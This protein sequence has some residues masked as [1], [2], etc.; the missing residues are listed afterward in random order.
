MVLAAV[1]LGLLPMHSCTCRSSAPEL[2]P[3][4]AE[5]HGGF[6]AVITP[7]KL[8]DRVAGMITPGGAEPPGEVALPTMLP[9]PEQADLPDNFPDGVPVPEGSHVMAVQ[10]LAN[11]ARN[12]VFTTEAENREVFSLY[13][14]TMTRN[15]WGDPTQEYEGRDNAFLSFKKGDTITNISVS[16]DPRTGK[17][18]VAVMYYEEKPLPF[19]EF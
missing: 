1:A 17:R 19:D 7:R 10:T 15:G 2:P 6:G 16:K 4:P 9:T 3:T 8:P 5:R 11:D 13:R 12:V 18:V 14:D